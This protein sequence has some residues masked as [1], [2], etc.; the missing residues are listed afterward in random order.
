M[1]PLQS[2]PDSAEN[3]DRYCL[4]R[5]PPQERASF[6]LALN[7]DEALRQE[8]DFVRLLVE[9]LRPYHAEVRASARGRAERSAP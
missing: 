8:T 5:M 3:I 6:E 2:T 4:D 7:D 1:K 9:A